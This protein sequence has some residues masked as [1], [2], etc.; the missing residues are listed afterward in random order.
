MHNLAVSGSFDPST[1]M[2]H[3]GQYFALGCGVESGQGGIEA[4][5]S[6]MVRSAPVH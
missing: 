5:V 6:A 2:E 1:A 4:C 3:M